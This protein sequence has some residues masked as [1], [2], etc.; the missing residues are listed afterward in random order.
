MHLIIRIV[1]VFTWRSRDP[2]EFE[3]ILSLADHHLNALGQRL[4]LQQDEQLSQ[5][6]WRTH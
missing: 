2:C 6:P 1:W 4:I 3:E 5:S